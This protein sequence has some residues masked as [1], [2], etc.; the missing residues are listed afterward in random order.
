MREFCGGHART[1]AQQNL[2]LR[3]VRDES[4][5]DVWRRLGGLDLGDGR[6]ATRS[7]TWSAAPAPTAASSGSPRSMGLNQAFQ[8]RVESMRIDD[9]LTRQIHIK[10]SGCPNGC[11]PAPHRQHRL[12]RCVDQGRRTH[13]AGLC[14]PRRGQLRGRQRRLRQRLKLRL[15]AKRVP[16]VVE[17]WLKLLRGGP[18][19]G[20]GVQRLRRAGRHCGVRGRGRELALP[21]EY[22]AETV[23][24]FV[25]WN[26][27]RPFASSAAKGSARSEPGVTRER[28][29]VA[30]G[31]T[32][33]T[34]GRGA[35]W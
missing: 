14:P 34:S 20:R 22:T 12:L 17:R 18:Q 23:D 21:A 8:E 33:R 19:R 10:M 9:P 6:C 25:D 30:S 4:L 32:Q 35:A 3:W 16:E 31:Y 27:D 24:D 13:P 5:Y 28:Q 1:T 15:P 7:T 26:R 11:S 2:V 29:I